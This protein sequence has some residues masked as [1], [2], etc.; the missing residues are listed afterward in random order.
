MIS[1]LVYRVEHDGDGAGPYFDGDGPAA[2][3]VVE[4]WRGRASKR[5]RPIPS[6]DPILSTYKRPG[7]WNTV[8]F[9]FDTIG[10]LASWFPKKTR[11]GLAKLGFSIGVYSAPVKISGSKQSVFDKTK[12]KL[13]KTI[14]LTDPTIPTR[15]AVPRVSNPNQLELAL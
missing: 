3:E 13:V 9:G 1:P 15:R 10:Q 5:N 7:Q 8:K 4:G 2:I 14:S 6:I 11:A 12:A